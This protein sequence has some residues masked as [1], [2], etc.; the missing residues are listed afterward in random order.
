MDA[1]RK[2]IARPNWLDQLRITK[3]FK[4]MV[5]WLIL[6][7]F[8]VKHRNY[9][10]FLYLPGY[11]FIVRNRVLRP[12]ILWISPPPTR[13]PPTHPAGGAFGGPRKSF[14]RHLLFLENCRHVWFFLS[15]LNFFLLFSP[16]WNV[17]IILRATFFLD[18]RTQ[19]WWFLGLQNGIPKAV[20]QIGQWNST[21]IPLD[22][23]RT[24]NYN[25][26][27]LIGAPSCKRNF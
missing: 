6:G 2:I 8:L 14:A 3:I 20:L 25:T 23:C 27:K 19:I 11:F 7:N 15:F 21:N 22:E 18:F 24:K 16:F 17:A 26:V 9:R 1:E 5:L 10:E 4:N 12:V 13:F